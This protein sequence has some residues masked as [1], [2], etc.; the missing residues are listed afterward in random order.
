MFAKSM[1]QRVR[2]GKRAGG[3][4]GERK[5]SGPCSGLPPV[6]GAGPG[7]MGGQ[8]AKSVPSLEGWRGLKKIWGQS[9][10]WG[11]CSELCSAKNYKRM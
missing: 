4:A 11:R 2:I 7:E 6:R 9:G 8:D 1:Q 3:L 5:R 10:A